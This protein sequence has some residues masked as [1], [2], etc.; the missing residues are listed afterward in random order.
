M[1]ARCTVNLGLFI[2]SIYR[3]TRGSGPPATVGEAICPVRTRIGLLTADRRDRWWDFGPAQGDAAPASDIGN[4]IRDVGLPF[5]DRFGSLADVHAWLEESGTVARPA[6]AAE[7][8]A[9]KLALGDPEGARLVLQ[10]AREI[11]LLRDW[12]R[13]VA[14]RLGVALTNEESGGATP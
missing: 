7:V 2:P 6:N 5:F 10:A 4:L 1:L 14:G 12:I 9:I 3:A 13:S 11:P 8:A